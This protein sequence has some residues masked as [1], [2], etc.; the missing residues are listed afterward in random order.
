MKLLGVACNAFYNRAHSLFRK[1]NS[2]KSFD[3][4]FSE[5]GYTTKISE[6]NL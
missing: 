1:G 4:A 6:R 5:A 3:F 2:L